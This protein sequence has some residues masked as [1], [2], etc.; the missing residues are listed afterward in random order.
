VTVFGYRVQRRH[1]RFAGRVITVVTDEV[2]MPDGVTVN[3]DWIQ[4]PGAVGAVALDEQGRVLLIN[5]YR[6]ALRRRLWELPAGLLDAEGESPLETARR[7]L[8][9][10]ADMTAAQW[11]LLVDVAT[12]PGCSNEVIRVFLARDLMPV[13]EAERYQRREEESEMETAWLP[14]EEAVAWVAEGRILNGPAVAGILAAARARD[15]GWT[16]LR[17]ALTPWPGTPVG[18]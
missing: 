4:H 8:H 7:E 1:E 9:E 15:A 10:E 12:S 11:D 6:H 18:G 16:P 3:R 17:P 14:L 2:T 5:Q 13:P